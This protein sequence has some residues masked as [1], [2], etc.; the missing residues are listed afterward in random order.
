MSNW[1]SRLTRVAWVAPTAALCALVTRDQQY[2]LAKV[3]LGSAQ[4]SVLT[5]TALNAVGGRAF[6]GK[7]RGR[8]RAATCG[9]VAAPDSPSGV[10]VFSPLRGPDSIR[11]S[12]TPWEV[13]APGRLAEHS[14]L[15]DTW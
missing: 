10:F 8:A 5:F 9:H 7:C 2:S 13:R 1:C 3:T 12:G 15:Q 14:T 4:Q 6:P 11:E